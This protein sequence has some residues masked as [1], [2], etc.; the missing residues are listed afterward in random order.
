MPNP[1]EQILADLESLDALRR[2]AGDGLAPAQ[3]P[4]VNSH[5]HLPPN[6]S[7]FHSVE[8]AIDLAASQGMDVIGVSNY[9]DFGVYDNFV[10]AVRAKGIFPLF[11]LEIICMR[12]DLR[13]S[14][15]KVNDPGNPGK[16]YL[17]GKGITRF[18]PMTDR[19]SELMAMIRR[20]DAARMAE[21]ASR[22]EGRFAAFDVA[23]NLDADAVIGRV[24]ARHGSSRDTVVLQERH[25][26]QAFQERLFEIVPAAD[27]AAKLGKVLGCEPMSAIDDAVGI[28]GEIRSALM[29][30]GKIAFVPET[31]CSFAEARELILELGGIPCYPTLADGVSP[32]T[33]FESS[34]DQLV[35]RMQ[36]SRIHCAE[37]IP[38]R[39][40]A[41]VLAEYASAMRKAGIVVTAGTEHNTLSLGSLEPDCKDQPMDPAL[42]D[43]FWEGACVVAA[44]QL[45]TARGECGFVDA[46][47]QPN[48]AYDTPEQRIAALARLGAATIESYFRANQ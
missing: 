6:F 47:G 30:A 48:E 8:Q 21:M 38:T 45:L 7:A 5:I 4:K 43:L 37:F 1:A 29:K 10:E 19:A 23:T 42:R 46:A 39:N 33:D 2:H 26:A 17:C 24:V 31:F 36:E 41:G 32:L 34:P 40:T 12:D 35:S 20:N 15:V 9:Y 13:D 11:G 28:Q 18:G 3:R 27:R 25:L 14:G 16:M 22:M 44:H